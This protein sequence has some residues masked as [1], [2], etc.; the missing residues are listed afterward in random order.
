MHWSEITLWACLV[1][2][3]LLVG[4][5]LIRLSSAIRAERQ[6][7]SW[8]DYRLACIVS[9]SIRQVRAGQHRAAEREWGRAA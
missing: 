5:G 3:C 4:F 9:E 1:T 6:R 8:A 7:R 2:A